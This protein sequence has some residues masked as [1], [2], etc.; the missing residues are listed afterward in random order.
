MKVGLY[1]GSFNPI[2]VGHLIIAE[3]MTRQF[4]EVWFVI[5]PQNPFKQSKDLLDE[6][7]RLKLINLCIDDHP[8]LK[9]SIIEFDLPK[10]SYTENT[11]KHLKDLH[12]DNS[13][14]L[15]MGADNIG[16]LHK[17]KNVEYILSYPIH[18]YP[19]KGYEL[20][21]EVLEKLAGNIKISDAPT[22]ELSGT[23]IRK[24]LKENTSVS[25]MLREKVYDYI[26]K[27]SLYQ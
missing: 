7:D 24:S 20:D 14:S 6:E 13:F 21:K 16:G 25:F 11:L 19:R 5:S 27:N 8:K 12:P 10:P 23:F 17:W 18:V 3:F 9:V 2:H 26:I 15:I 1:F 4:D 22:I